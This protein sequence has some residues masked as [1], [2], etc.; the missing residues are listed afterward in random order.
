MRVCSSEH[1]TTTWRFFHIHNTDFP[2]ANRTTFAIVEMLSSEAFNL[3]VKGAFGC[4]VMS[5]EGQETIVHQD[6][7]WELLFKAGFV[8]LWCCNL[9]TTPYIYMLRNNMLKF[10]PTYFLKFFLFSLF[11][12]EKNYKHQILRP[13]KQ[14]ADWWTFEN[15]NNMCLHHYFPAPPKSPSFT[16]PCCFGRSDGLSLCESKIPNKITMTWKDQKD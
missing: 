8:D 13:W 14:P 3:F 6:L 11:H 1:K 10:V 9:W 5:K 2:L 12:V 4:F 16:L 7:L 15:F